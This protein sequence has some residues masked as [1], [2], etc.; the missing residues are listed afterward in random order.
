[1]HFK[2]KM[3]SVIKMN[4]EIFTAFL[5]FECIFNV[6]VVANKT[7]I[8]KSG[9]FIIIIIIVAIMGYLK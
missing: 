9:F 1:M 6:A 7:K 8:P 2:I 3:K 5:M 4:L